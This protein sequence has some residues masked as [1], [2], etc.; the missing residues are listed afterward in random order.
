[1]LTRGFE[2]LVPVFVAMSPLTVLPVFLTMTDGFT[3]PR[4]RAL[5]RRAIVTALSIAMALVFLGQAL[6]RFLGITVE[7]LRVAGGIILLLI[8]IHDLIFTRE[9]RKVAEMNA[10]VG[11]VP[12]GTPLIVGPATMTTLM[13]HADSHG[14]ALVFVALC[15]NLLLTWLLLH[16]ANHIKAFVPPSVARAFGKV[17]SLFLAAIAV[18]MLRGGIAAFVKHGLPT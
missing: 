5:A 1:M 9:R 15:V 12:L 3:V 17:M 10:D 13:V 2:V 7:D 14:H 18:A 6:F 8:A 16:Y 4:M 11:V